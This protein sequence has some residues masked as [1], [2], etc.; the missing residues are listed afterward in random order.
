MF[1]VMVISKIVNGLFNGNKQNYLY[2]SNQQNSQS[3]GKKQNAHPNAN[4][5]KWFNLAIVSKRI[6]QMVQW[7]D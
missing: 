3:C 2:N 5:A 6:Q 4:L 7:V 1:S